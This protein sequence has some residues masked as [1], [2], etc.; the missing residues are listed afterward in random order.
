MASIADY[1]LLGDCQGA[2]L[3]SL[4]GSVDWWCP[5]RFD[6]P[7][8]FSRVLDPGAGHWS[9]RPPGDWAV[10]RRYVE[11][12]MVVQT[13]F[14]TGSGLLRLTDALILGPGERGHGI[15]YGSPHVLVRHLEAVRGEVDVELELAAR[16]EYGLVTPQL[17]PTPVGIDVGGGADR[18]LLTGDQP[19]E[20]EAGQVTARFCLRDSETAVFV[21][22]H[23]RSV[24]PASNAPDGRAALRDTVAGWQSWTRLHQGYQGLYR[25]EVTRSGLVLQ[26][27]TYQPTGAVTA[28]AT[29][30]LPEEV[31][32][33]ANWDYRFGW[34]RDGSFTLKALWVAA[35]PDEGQRFFDWIAASAG[36]IGDGHVPIMFGVGGEHDLTEHRLDHLAGYAESRPVRVGNDA[37][38]QNQLDVLGEVLECAWVL[39]DQLGEL[40]PTTA[41]L[42]CTLADQAARR[43]Q[44]PDAGIWEGREGQRHYLTSKL[45][46]W[47]ALD[48]AVKLADRLGGE[49]DVARWEA[50]RED[51][52]AAILDR[53]W[54]E[55]VKAFTGAFG[56]DHLDAGVLL[57]PIVGFLPGD[58]ERVV[59]TLD[60]IE[61]NLSRGALVQRWTGS[62][63]EGAFIISSYWLAAGRA[64]AGQVDRAKEIFETV[65][66]YANDLGLLS[67][68]IDMRDG[69]LLGNFPQAL[70]HIGLVNAAWA[71]TQADGP[72]EQVV[73]DRPGPTGVAQT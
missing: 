18:L 6:A 29:T 41:T 34:L 35:C 23:R 68:E 20:I 39:R 36:P 70:S 15:G 30:S 42:L 40:P 52:R 38:T 57:M 43:W 1:A 55:S 9:V 62:G 24:D 59:A 26:A 22:Q 7:S 11:D 44:E 54:D 65:T 4:H 61:Q 45:M 12:T 67:E 33:Q 14:S 63:N 69:A 71:I 50:A 72:H 31:G 17:T 49:A 28:A 2:A 58:D 27:L 51:V 53:G 10:N 5:A 73:C 56:S 16:P 8:V 66:G 46:C 48:R 25:E 32:G 64:L 3:V 21:L 13:D 60:A 19:L 37:W 47:A